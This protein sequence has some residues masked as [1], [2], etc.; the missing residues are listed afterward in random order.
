MDENEEIDP[1]SWTLY[2]S[3]ITGLRHIVVVVDHVASSRNA[4]ERT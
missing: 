2:G 3:L 1:M 4:R